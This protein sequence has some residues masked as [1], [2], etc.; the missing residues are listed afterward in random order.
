M[1]RV[2]LFT[3]GAHP[4]IG[5]RGASARAPENTLPSF[6]RALEEG[7]D[8]IELDVH[9]TAD[10]VPVVIHD[11]TLDRTT[12][13]TGA[14]AALPLARV[15]A[16]DAG[17]RFTADGGRTYPW[18]A[19]GVRVPTLDEVLVAHPDTPMIVEIKTPAASPAVAHALREHDAASR[20]VLMSFEAA[21]LE[22]FAH[23]GWMLGATSREA[24]ALLAP[25]PLRPRAESLRYRI[26]CVP[27]T[28]HGVPIPMH[29]LAAAAARLGRPT[30][31]WV[32]DDPAR[33]RRL[34]RRG[35]AGVVTN[36]PAEMIAERDRF[37]P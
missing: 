6:A 7:A 22:P 28:W 10:G 34:W 23:G 3:P 11:P 21:A 13:A 5:H 2:S 19:R 1:T 33:A 36:Q 18:R 14:V 15:Q 24:V 35:V 4:V 9:V 8:A 20:C 12:D 30:H 16:A 25:A 29:R 37:T 26:L 31:V 27:E 17:A 32:V